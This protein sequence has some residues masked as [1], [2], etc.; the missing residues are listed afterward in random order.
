LQFYASVF[1]QKNGNLGFSEVHPQTMIDLEARVMNRLQNRKRG[2][3]IE[4]LQAFLKEP[5]SKIL[6]VLNLYKK[7]RAGYEV[8]ERR[9]GS[10]SRRTLDESPARAPQ[11]TPRAYNQRH[12]ETCLLGR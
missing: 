12:Y 10:G 11:P 7:G 5:Q 1:L 4:Q 9:L 6:Q 8:R 2:Q 3:T